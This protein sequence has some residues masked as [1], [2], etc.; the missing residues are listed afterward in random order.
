MCP[1]GRHQP[2]QA[3]MHEKQT[4]AAS[5]CREVSGTEGREDAGKWWMWED[6]LL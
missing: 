5:D 2:S 4:Q 6:R 1:G 3:A